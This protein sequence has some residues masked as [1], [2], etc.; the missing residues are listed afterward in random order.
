MDG[1]TPGTLTF[2]FIVT[3]QKVY[4]YLRLRRQGPPRMHP[5]GP[6]WSIAVPQIITDSLSLSF[7]LS[8]RD[9]CVNLKICQGF[10]ALPPPGARIR[11]DFERRLRINK[12]RIR[13]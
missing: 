1:G 11:V 8:F 10:P 9:S 2:Y 12:R 6:V 4:T 13:P 5:F 7:F 3:C